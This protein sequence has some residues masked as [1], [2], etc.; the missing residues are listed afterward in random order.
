MSRSRTCF[1]TLF[2]ACFAHLFLEECFSFW[3]I[4]MASVWKW[5][6]PTRKLKWLEYFLT[7][8]TRTLLK[9]YSLCTI[10][11]NLHK[12]CP[13]WDAFF[14]AHNWIEV[15]SIT[16]NFVSPIFFFLKGASVNFAERWRLHFGLSIY[17]TTI[18]QWVKTSPQVNASVRWKVQYQILLL[19][20]WWKST[21]FS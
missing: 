18:H 3:R 7:R 21:P 8:L 14:Q 2:W 1:Q 6:L 15:P 4:N 5:T 20:W 11:L 17:Y 12:R 9:I 10:T 19:F 16:T 13:F